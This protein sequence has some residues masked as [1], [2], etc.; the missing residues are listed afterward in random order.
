MKILILYQLT[1]L[2]CVLGLISSHLISKEWLRGKEINHIRN[3][4]PK[5]F[6]LKGITNY[7]SITKRKFTATNILVTESS[8]PM[9][10]MKDA[11]NE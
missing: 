8:L 4:E 11:R 7:I 1:S 6:N 3:F 10:E 2:V 9:G 5:Q